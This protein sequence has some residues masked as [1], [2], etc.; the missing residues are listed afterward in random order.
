MTR[1]APIACSLAADDLRQ[2]LDEI[3]AVG[4]ESLVARDSDGLRHTLC[5]HSDPQTRRRLE[6]I[7]AAEAE[8]CS[9][10]SLTLV[11]QKGELILILEAPEDGRSVADGLA[12][13]FGTPA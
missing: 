6:R 10:L 9:F 12:G 13:A 1:S 5:F 4:A 7:I 8:C 11:E 3:A 2:R